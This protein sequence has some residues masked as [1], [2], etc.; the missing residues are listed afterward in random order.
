LRLGS[1]DALAEE[2]GVAPEVFERRERN[3][4]DAVLDRDVSGGRKRGDPMCECSDELV[5]RFGWQR[6]VDPAVT[7]GEFDLR[8]RDQP[9]RAQVAEEGGDRWFTRQDCGFRPI[10]V[11][12]RQVDGT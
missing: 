9:T 11:D 5:E 6:T 3:G 2:V 8:D 10:L 7:L 1:A 12:P 4:G